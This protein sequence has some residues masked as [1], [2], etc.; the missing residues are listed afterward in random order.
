MFS[1]THNRR[2]TKARGHDPAGMP[3]TAP[4]LCLWCGKPFTRRRNGG[5]RQ[6]F[7][8]PPHRIAFHTA[9][10]RWAER[11]VASGALTVAELQSGSAVACTLPGGH[12]AVDLLPEH[13][14][15]ELAISKPQ[16]FGVTS[17]GS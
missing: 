17:T 16:Q 7:C 13:R 14:K 10:R 2:P 9:A 4:P 6:S 15:S 5:S 12:E 3:E 8:G 11:A 1:V